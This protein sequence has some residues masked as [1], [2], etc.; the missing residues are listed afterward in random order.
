MQNENDK[1]ASSGLSAARGAQSVRPG[2][3][4]VYDISREDD[5]RWICDVPELP[6]CTAYGTTEKAAIDDARL[7]AVAI[8]ID[9]LRNGEEP[10]LVGRS[11][12]EGSPNP[13][14]AK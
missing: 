8:L 6:G 11:K 3:V 12:S 14:E 1:L 7:L 2:A 9:R 10:L 13:T 4:L 5:G